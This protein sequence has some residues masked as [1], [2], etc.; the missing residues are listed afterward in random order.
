MCSWQ[1][2]N[3]VVFYLTLDVVETN[4]SVLSKKDW[5][6][7]E[8]RPLSDTPVRN[9]LLHTHK[10]NILFYVQNNKACCWILCLLVFALTSLPPHPRFMDSAKPPSSS[11]GLR[12]WCVSTNTTVWSGQVKNKKKLSSNNNTVRFNLYLIRVMSCC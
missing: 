10:N 4:C 2:E 11:I 5:K 8:I 9:T 6:S 3:G 1:E 7:C 12:E